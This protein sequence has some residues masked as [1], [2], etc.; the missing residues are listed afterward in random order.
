MI[1]RGRP[2]NSPVNEDKWVREK[3]EGELAKRELT[4]LMPPEAYTDPS[5]EWNWSPF[6]KSSK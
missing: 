5:F 4:S 3:F 2:C 1:R 6:L